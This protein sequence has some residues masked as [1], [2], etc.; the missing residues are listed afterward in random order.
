MALSHMPIG[1]LLVWALLVLIGTR[2]AWEILFSSLRHFP[3]PFAAKF[4]NIWRAVRTY[5]GRVDLDTWRLHQRYGIAVRIGPNTISLSDPNLIKTIY[6][7][8]NAWRKSEMYKPN[9][10]MVNGQRVEN[11]FNT[12]NEEWHNKMMKPIRNMY[13]LGKIQDVEPWMDATLNKFTSKLESNFVDGSNAGKICMMDDWLGHFAWDVMGNLTFGKEYGFLDEQK[14]VQDLI[15]R[16]TQGLY[17]FA[18]VSQIPWIDNFLDKNPIKRFGPEPLTGL[19]LLALQIINDSQQQ[20]KTGGSKA[21]HEVE[22]LMDKVL[23]LKQTHSD[24]V[25]D[26][27]VLQYLM[28]NVTAGGDS[29]S[30][31]MR[32]VVYYLAKTPAAYSKLTAE[33][34][35]AALKLPALFKEASQLPYLDAVIREAMRLSPGVGL[36]IERIVPEQGLTLADGRFIPAGTRVGLNPGVTNHDSEVFGDDVFTFNPDR[37]LQAKGESNA[38]FEERLRKMRETAEFVFGAGNRICMGRHVATVEIYKLIATMYS[39]YDIKLENRSHEW[40]YR[41]AWFI[42]QT[43]MPMII[44]R[45]VHS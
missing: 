20:L 31:A 10:I 32:S 6:P 14:D 33:L 3:G 22:T 26:N 13:T 43:D 27:Q 29:T 25:D 37:W 17:Y 30:S 16:S 45:R 2:L 12:P 24:L 18:P 42:Y 15:G 23:E 40:K 11:L 19:V 41:N 5:H 9:D 44:S 36:V 39:I 35:Q 4:T 7:V 21:R 28:L 38:E 34:E 8:R 1:Q